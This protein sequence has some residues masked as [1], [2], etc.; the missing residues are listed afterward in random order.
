M[1]INNKKPS[2][3]R[4]MCLSFEKKLAIFFIVKGIKEERLIWCQLT[5]AKLVVPHWVACRLFFLTR[6]VIHLSSY[7]SCKINKIY[8]MTNYS[9]IKA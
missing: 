7:E 9:E 2:V 8:E 5:D 4:K 6:M 3:G 1:K